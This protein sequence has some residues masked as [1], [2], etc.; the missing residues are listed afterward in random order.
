MAEQSNSWQSLPR[1]EVI[2]TIERRYPQRIPMVRTKWWG[3]G[4]EELHGDELD[5]FATYPEDATILFIEPI[6][7][8]KM[9]LS[10]PVVDEGAHDARVVI[11]DW[12]KLDEFVD[13]LPDP[14]T[15]PQMEGLQEQAAAV[16]NQGQYLMYGWWRLFFERPWG[17]R[18][19]QNLL[20]DYYLYPDE[21]HRLHNA[22]CDHY[23]KYLEW[24]IRELQPEAFWTSDDLGHQKQLFMRPESFRDLIKPYYMKIGAYLE[25]KNLHW[26]LHSCGNN[27]AILDDLVE[28]GI[29]VFHPV[30]KGT[31]DY[32]SVAAEYGDRMTFLVGFDVQHVL[33]EDTTE[34]VRAEVRRI[35]DTFDRKDGG[36][37]I[38]AGNGILPG[39]PLD[40]IEAFLDES[41][42]Y[43]EL[44]RQSF[45]P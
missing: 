38:A 3:E 8:E 9:G 19:M 5:R 39:T 34:Q 43:G 30:Q 31:M 18:G 20:M 14:N 10:W 11:D 27:T 33:Q 35:I 4:L 40:N 6:Q 2:K 41:L 42:R 25:R 22:L 26:W 7:P 21:I 17:I 16:R 29:D 36:L 12:A 28:A 15:D 32:A 23:I 24:G 13:K 45:R 1:E 44:H 37:C